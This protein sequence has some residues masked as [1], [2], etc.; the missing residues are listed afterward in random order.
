MALSLGASYLGFILYSKSPRS[1]DLEEFASLNVSLTD[2]F[3]V[4]VDVRPE[5]DKVKQ[6]VSAGFDFFQIHFSDVHDAEYLAEHLA[7]LA[8]LK[9]LENSFGGVD[10]TS[11]A[12]P[13]VAAI[14]AKLNDLRLRAGK[15]PMGFLNPFIYANPTAFNDVTTGCN[16]NG[17]KYGFTATKGWD[18]ATGLGTPNYALLKK[19]V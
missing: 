14:F 4:V 19:L 9:Y 6:Y 18:P 1:I 10:G 11:A 8:A 17:G 13:V 16:N 3:R 2:S 12:T 15:P 7:A 5:M